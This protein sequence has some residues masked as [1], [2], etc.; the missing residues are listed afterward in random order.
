MTG[1]DAIAVIGALTPEA[2]GRLVRETWIEWATEQPDPKPSWLVGWDELNAGQ[3]EVD[4]RI[5]SAVAAA[6]AAHECAWVPCEQ[7]K[8][9]GQPC[10]CSG[11]L[12]CEI[13]RREIEA[14]NEGCTRGRDGT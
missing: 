9:P 3:R 12:C 10:A 14:F 2:L 7:C 6:V 4:I 8:T 1:A 13:Q 11:G 5:G